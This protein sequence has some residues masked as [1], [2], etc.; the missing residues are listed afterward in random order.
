MRTPDQAKQNAAAG[1]G[2]LDKSV[3]EQIDTTCP[4]T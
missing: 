4:P 1:T 2:K 3:L